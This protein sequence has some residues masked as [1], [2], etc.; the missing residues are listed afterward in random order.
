MR[1]RARITLSVFAIL[2]VVFASL[3]AAACGDGGPPA[4]LRAAPPP[5]PGM[6]L[7][8]QAAD[9]FEVVATWSPVVFQGD[10][11]RE[12]VR[13]TGYDDGTAEL[14]D[15]LQA[16]GSE[17]FELPSPPEG[18]TME[19]FYCIRSLR[20]ASDGS[21]VVAPTDSSSYRRCVDFQYTSP[22]SF[23]PPPDSLEVNP[24]QA[25]ALDSIRILPDTLRFT[26][27]TEAGKDSTTQVERVFVAG[28]PVPRDTTVTDTAPTATSH[29]AALLYAG[30]EVVGC[31]GDC[32]GFPISTAGWE[33][34][35]PVYLS[36]R[37]G[38]DVGEEW[39]ARRLPWFRVLADGKLAALLR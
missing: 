24:Q 28:G 15:T 6:D 37:P 5:S 11:I 17:T 30:G 14:Q 4:E 34:G 38:Y 21:P 3:A 22:L 36:G 33:D 8:A 9:T 13:E 2:A 19:G 29:V 1:D 20:R 31:D 18:E 23:P 10:T 12:F 7:V 35:V 25:V 32:S 39:Q 27:L 16:V 26:F